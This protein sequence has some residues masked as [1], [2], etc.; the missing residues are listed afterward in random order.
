MKNQ[1]VEIA[2]RDL[3]STGEGVGEVEGLVVFVDGALPNERVRA[4][5]TQTKHQYAI[6]KLLDIIEPSPERVRPICPLFSRCGGCQLMHLSYGG[7]LMLKKKRVAD[8]FSRIGGLKD[9]P[10]QPVKRSPNELSYRNKITLPIVWRGGRKVVGLYAKRSHEVVEV[11]KCYIHHQLGEKVYQQVRDRIAGSNI[12]VFNPKKRKGE[13]KHIAIRSAENSGESI[14]LLLSTQK[15]SEDLKILASSLHQIPEVVGVVHGRISSEENSL[16]SNDYQVLVGSGVLVET[17][18]K[19]QVQISAPSFFQVN[20]K[21]A[22]QLY[23]KALAFANVSNEDVVV[24]AYS[25]LGLLTMMIAERAKRVI[26]IEISPS[27]CADARQNSKRNHI[28]NIEWVKGLVEKE[29][30]HFEGV[31]IAFINPPRKG[32]D[33]Q[34]IDAIAKNV[35]EKIVYISCDPATLARDAAHLA[36]LGWRCQEVQPFDMFPQTSHVETVA[37]FQKGSMMGSNR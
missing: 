18:G 17:F 12:Q 19:Y 37:L 20:A 15:V 8:A 25:G 21:Q 28:E 24:D 4:L 10:I 33:P 31:S 14:V 35:R 36:E 22:H 26:G 11:E 13:L 32:C 9:L 1:E 6:G 27:S 29:M 16:F 7:Q 23:E 2:I 3:T 34:V 30:K 5:I